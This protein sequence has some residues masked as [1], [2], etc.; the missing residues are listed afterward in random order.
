MQT[1]LLSTMPRYLMRCR[2][3]TQMFAGAVT[4]EDR[5]FDLTWIGELVV[6]E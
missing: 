1:L 2:M 6:L 5:E 3:A 4:N